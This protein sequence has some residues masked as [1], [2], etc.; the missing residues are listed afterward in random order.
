MPTAKAKPAT[1]KPPSKHHYVRVNGPTGL[2]L[3]VTNA[4]LRDVPLALLQA[5]VSDSISK[6]GGKTNAIATHSA[7]RKKFTVRVNF[8]RGEAHVQMSNEV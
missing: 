8:D 4:A 5:R 1:A 7:G 2:R 6:V 3:Y